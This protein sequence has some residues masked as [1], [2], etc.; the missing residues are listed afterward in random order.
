M[1]FEECADLAAVL[2]PGAHLCVRNALPAQLR[3]DGL[4][5]VRNKVRQVNLVEAIDA[6]A[7]HR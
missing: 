5:E 6:D 4:R 7:T 2:A 1:V 3:H